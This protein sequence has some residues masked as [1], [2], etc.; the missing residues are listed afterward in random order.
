MGDARALAL[1]SL[2]RN[3]PTSVSL[4]LSDGSEKG[5]ALRSGRTR[6]EHAADVMAPFLEDGARAELRD[7][8]GMVV[9]L[10]QWYPPT[11]EPPTPQ[12]APQASGGTDAR[13]M[14]DLMLRAQDQALRRHHEMLGTL[15]E[16]N[17]G[18][19]ELLGSRISSLEASYGRMLQAQLDATMARAEAEAA[20]A[21]K[22]DDSQLAGLAAHVLGA[23][24]PGV[25]AS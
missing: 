20:A 5:V 7:K 9:A 16:A 18:M 17:N 2:R 24:M 10:V 25:K 21:T 4:V 6:W 19:I 15:L 11:I 13:W 3:K 22:A 14:L 12:G 23:A 1:D 8:T